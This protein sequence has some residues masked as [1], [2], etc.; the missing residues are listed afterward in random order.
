[1]EAINVSIDFDKRLAAH[2]L[3]GSQAMPRCWLPRASSLNRC[4]CH[5]TG[6]ATI[7]REIESGTFPFRREFE[8]IHLNVEARLCELIGDA[9][10]RLHTARSRND[11][12][13]PICDSGTEACA[14]A[15]SGLLALQRALVQ[16][17][18]H[19]AETI[20]PGFTHMQPAQP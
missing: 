20:M 7:S 10:G 15:D 9:A 18:A 8:D 1:M 4:Q 11:Q 12:W 19:H 17:A 13:R 14:R 6:L 3:K 5:Q 16:Q 2:D